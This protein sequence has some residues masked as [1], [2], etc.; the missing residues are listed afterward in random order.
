MGMCLGEKRDVKNSR[1]VFGRAMV[2]AQDS[3]I[4]HCK[5]LVFYVIWVNVFDLQCSSRSAEIHA[6][7]E[8]D[9][10]TD[11]KEAPSRLRSFLFSM[12]MVPISSHVIKPFLFSFIP[13]SQSPLNRF[14]NNNTSRSWSSQQQLSPSTV[15]GFPNSHPATLGESTWSQAKFSLRTDNP[16]RTLPQPQHLKSSSHSTFVIG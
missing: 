8:S 14:P 10:S 15:R 12:Q 13:H 1:G 6:R 9:R 7:N 16:I 11:L 3:L 2:N 5:G 4:Q